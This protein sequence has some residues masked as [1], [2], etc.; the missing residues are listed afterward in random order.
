MKRDKLRS[1]GEISQND[2]HRRFRI[3]WR[4]WRLGVEDSFLHVI[5]IPQEKKCGCSCDLIG[6]EH[7]KLVPVLLGSVCLGEEV[8]FSATTRCKC[9]TAN[10]P[11]IIHPDNLCY[12]HVGWEPS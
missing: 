12:W 4:L 10:P 1:W 5:L 8:V 6:Y 3:L 2:A 9:P 11:I 7:K